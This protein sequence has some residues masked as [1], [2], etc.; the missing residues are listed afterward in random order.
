MDARFILIIFLLYT[1]ILFIAGWLTSRKSN[2]ESYYIGNRASKWFVV[3]YGM[4]GASLSGVTFISVPGWV[5]ERS[6]SYMAVV[7][8]YLLGYAVIA[9][10]LLPLYYRLKLT[11]IYTY[12]DQR[13]GKISYKTGASFFLLS[14]YIGAS[15]R[16]FLVINV[17]QVF[18]FD[19][20]DVPFWITV[21]GFLMLIMLYTLKG[22]IKTIVWTDMLQT[23]F[24][25][26]ALGLSIY[27]IADIW[28]GGFS[29]LLQEVKTSSL[30]KMFFWDPKSAYHFVKLFISGIFITIVMTG[31]DQDMMQKN[32]SCR[33]LKEAKRN[34]YWMSFMLVPVNLLFLFL[35]AALFLFAAKYNISI[36]ERTDN[37]FPLIAF[38][39]LGITAGIVFLI[40]LIAAAYSS[41]DSALTALTT[42]FSID[43]LE[44]KKK[45]WSD[46]K[47][48][49]VRMLIHIGSAILLTTIIIIFRANS[50]E[51]VIQKLFEFAGY[52]YGPLLGLYSF[53]LFT[54]LNT[55]EKLVPVIAIIAP[56]LS[57][58]T[59]IYSK[60]WYDWE[61]G[62][63]VLIIN[64][65]FTFLMLL[66][67]SV[68]MKK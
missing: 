54:K 33:N 28:D 52:T 62:F 35:G 50:K 48:S 46:Q 26:V 38:S 41:A 12:L 49:R 58:F 4:I 14:R 15:F 47:K 39:H 1:A 37:L 57:Y 32:L 67:C 61:I 34:M 22:G 65:A 36:P 64:G 53:G 29:G 17:L 25:L 45:N 13:Y 9:N 42:S 30:S 8:G 63:E 66:L 23:T 59:T 60:K 11:S 68:K 19:R 5:G 40:G 21:A 3:A 24:M 56:V 18:V 10:I 2:E 43:I 7:L 44:I 6:F 55:R 27:Y 16:M 31:L 51:S 20:W